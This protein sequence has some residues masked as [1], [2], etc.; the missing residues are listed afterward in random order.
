MGDR[1]VHCFDVK[2]SSWSILPIKG[3]S[4]KP[5]HGHV[6]VAVGNRL[7]IHGGMA[8]SAF[9]DDFHLMDLDKMSWSNIRRKK[10]TPSARAAHSGVA[11]GKDIYIFGGMSR[12]GA[13]DDLYKCDTCKC[14]NVFLVKSN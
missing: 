10:A 3:D 2:T 12:E 4:P 6:M 14:K 5:R 7:F 13:L 11:V 9:Y 1:Q 8:G